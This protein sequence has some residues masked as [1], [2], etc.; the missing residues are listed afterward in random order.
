MIAKSAFS[1]FLAPFGFSTS[2]R[3]IE[4]NKLTRLEQIQVQVAAAAAANAAAAGVVAAGAMVV[5]GGL[6]HRPGSAA[7][8][9]L[10]EAVDLILDAGRRAGHV[11]RAMFFKRS[12]GN[13]VARSTRA[14][15]ARARSI[16][17]D[18]V[19]PDDDGEE[20]EVRERERKVRD[21]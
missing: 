21:R 7:L 15:S 18:P 5:R 3:P 1:L 4:S 19:R 11:F 13:S 6:F 8:E 12:S 14:I 20:D 17:S 10:Q 2:R 16:L 9:L